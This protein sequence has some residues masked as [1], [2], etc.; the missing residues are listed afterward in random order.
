MNA[1]V[2][3]SLISAVGFVASAVLL[4]KRRKK[5][6]LSNGVLFPLLF[7]IFLYAFIVTSNFLEHSGITE[8]F[9]PI[10]DIA[11]I[12]FTLV[13]LFFVNNW[14]KQKS[15]E[16]IKNQEAWHRV[17][18]E[19]IADGVM[20]TDRN[21]TILRMNHTM[22]D[23]TGLTQA[24]AYGRNATEVLAFRDKNTEETVSYNP[25]ENVLS[26]NAS[27]GYPQGILLQAGNGKT[28]LVADSTSAIR[29]A[30]DELLGAV[31]IFRDMGRYEALIEQL[32]HNQKMEAVGQLAG[33]VAH[34]LNNM[35][36]GIMGAA[37]VLKLNFSDDGVHQYDELLGI[38]TDSVKSAGD[39]TSNLLAFSRRGKIVSTPIA[40]QD[41]IRKT[42]AIGQRTIDKLIRLKTECPPDPLMIVGDPSQLQN[43]L[44]NL[45]INSRD[46]MPHGG[47]I[48]ISAKEEH[49]DDSWCEASPFEI[50]SGQYVSIHVKDDG[51][52]ISP[53]NQ[54]R[55]FEPFFT[56]KEEGKGTGL[57]LAAV[58]R[59]VT[60]HLGAIKV[61]SGTG[62]GTTFSLYFPM[63][64]ATD[65]RRKRDTVL[66]AHGKGTVLLIEDEDL[67]RSSTKIILEHG[68]YDVYAAA[69]GAEGIGIYQKHRDEIN[70]VL[71]DMI[72][73]EMNG[74]EVF[75]ALCQIDPR[76]KVVM[77]SGFTQKASIPEGVKNF[78]KKPFS[79][80]DL[81]ASIQ[82][83]LA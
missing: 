23:F 82:K 38:I 81:L 69:S 83:A 55:I 34:D 43:A 30:T 63:V 54:K 33:G 42:V 74:V 79:Y 11:E 20:A 73:P 45:I 80:N 2:L 3:L 48:T 59:T 68:G 16:A 35:L 65:I 15:F 66:H 50:F 27:R 49:L 47:N 10:E 64:Q 67:L 71:L 4:V 31:G 62:K 22:E 58:Y 56:T 24:D 46:A 52:G 29:S 53:E 32:S 57:G 36:G 60:N 5:I 19:S 41:V 51:I 77:T 18:L 78:I 12:V 6:H 14:R 17:T 40:I 25:F 72:M 75:G 8:Y 61:T 7:A 26:G 9:D 44:L 76:V 21:G 70:V 1:T 28:T 37:D 39:L 13:F